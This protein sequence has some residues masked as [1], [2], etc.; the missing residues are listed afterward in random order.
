MIT[1]E[2][3]KFYQYWSKTRINYKTS[4]RPYLKGLS[5]GFAIGVGILLTIYQGWYTRANMQANTI[6][7]PFLF[8]L[9]ISIIAVFMAFIYRNYQWE[10]QEQRFQIISAKKQRAEKNL[11]H[12]ALGH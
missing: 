2:E 4:L 10:Q 1:E 8:L 11:S 12:A 9:A 6:L 5:I 7:N 3:E